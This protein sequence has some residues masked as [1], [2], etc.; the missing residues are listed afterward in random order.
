M[1][2]RWSEERDHVYFGNTNQCVQNDALCQIRALHVTFCSDLA[3]WIFGTL[4][5]L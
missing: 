3:A 4:N 2:S 5:L 1:S